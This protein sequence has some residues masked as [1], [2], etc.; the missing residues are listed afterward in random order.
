MTDI[1]FDRPCRLRKKQPT[2]SSTPTTNKSTRT[3]NSSTLLDAMYKSFP[4]AAVFTIVPGYV[5]PPGTSVSRRP[6]EPE[7]EL[8]KALTSLY[9]QRYTCCT[10]SQI[11]KLAEAKLPEIMCT[12]QQSQFLEQSTRGQS[13]SILWHEQRIGRITASNMGAVCRC[14]ETRYPTSLVCKIMQYSTPNAH[15]PALEWGRSK[16]DKARKAYQASM[17][18]QAQ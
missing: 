18:T 17:H 13:S 5:C 14:T 6:A 15:V 9:N 12:Q 7:L 8:P 16:E 11:L 1:S 3:L 2:N 10:T 4:Q